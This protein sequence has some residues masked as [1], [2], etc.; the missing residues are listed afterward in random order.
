VGPAVD[1]SSFSHMMRPDVLLQAFPF[2][3]RRRLNGEASPF[4]LKW[5]ALRVYFLQRKCYF[6]QH[7]KIHKRK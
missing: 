3:K 6:S 2:P 5:R 4:S 7:Q 1:F